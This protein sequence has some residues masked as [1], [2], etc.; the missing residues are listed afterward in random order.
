MAVTVRQL[1]VLFNQLSKFG[2]AAEKASEK[3]LELQTRLAGMEKTDE[4]YDKVKKDLADSQREEKKLKVETNKLTR[5]QNK[6]VGENTQAFK[7]L[8]ESTQEFRIEALKLKGEFKDVGGIVDRQV[9]S[10][11]RANDMVATFTAQ[12]NKASDRLKQGYSDEGTGPAFK[13]KKEKELASA[14][15][16]RD[17][18]KLLADIAKKNTENISKIGTDEFSAVDLKDSEKLLERV[19]KLKEMG[20]DISD[21]DLKIMKKNAESQVALGD[22][23]RRSNEIVN[24]TTK[25]TQEL[26]NQFQSILGDVPLIGGYLSDKV[27]SALSSL[28]DTLKK[29]IVQSLYSSVL[30]SKGLTIGLDGATVAATKLG[31]AMTFVTA[32]ANI[33]IALA[34]AAVAV[35]VTMAI[36]ARDFAKEVGISYDQAF[37]LQRTLAESQALMIGLGQSASTISNELIEV[38]GTIDKVTTGNIVQIGRVATKLGAETK[39]II[40]IQKQLMDMTGASADASMELINNIGRLSAAEGVGAGN[41]IADIATNMA[42]FAEF[43]TMGAQGLAEAAVQAAK[44]GSSLSNVNAFA[45]KLIDFESSITAEFEAQVLTGKQLNLERARELALQGDMAGL[46]KELQSTV[47]GLGDIQTMNRV[48]KRAISTAIGVSV[49]DLQK[50]SRGEAIEQKKTQEDLLQQLIEVN[51]KGFAGNAEAFGK[52]ETS[53]NNFLNYGD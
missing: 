17:T 43:S 14:E 52:G 18:A 36:K 11:G 45:E 40:S 50:I 39:D 1:E 20:V 4:G 21:E 6:L 49:A 23:Q 41:V 13:A 15:Y 44:V 34:V 26:G 51:K 3:T 8:A 33:L 10:Y 47:G 32:G 53:F 37:K 46:S 27:G 5:Q 31:T 38:F 24:L 9:A 7:T 19:N 2:D 16:G 25:A 42:T 35:F 12:A 48:E 30:A 28:G 29:N 22:A